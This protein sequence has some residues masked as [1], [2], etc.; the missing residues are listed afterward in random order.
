MSASTVAHDKCGNCDE[1]LD[2]SSQDVVR[3]NGSCGHVLHAACWLQRMIVSPTDGCSLCPQVPSIL[4]KSPLE[5]KTQTFFGSKTEVVS[6]AATAQGKGIWGRAWDTF[7]A[8]LSS[9][10]DDTH[11]ARLRANLPVV[12]LQHQGFTAEKLLGEL[13]YGVVPFLV[14]ETRYSSFQLSEL[15]FRWEH[16]VRGGLTETNFSSVLK[17]FGRSFLTDAVLNI[18]NLMDLCGKDPHRLAS[19]GIPAPYWS[20]LVAPNIM[21]IVALEKAGVRVQHFALFNFTMEE[22]RDE[23]GLTPTLLARMK[24]TRRDIEEFWCH[25]NPD[26]IDHFHLIFPVS[27]QKQVRPKF[28][29]SKG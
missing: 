23:M 19:L 14:K 9:A 8:L 22:W 25:S 11:A 26:E 18:A 4:Y 17:H 27:A 28:G 1:K 7:D 12:E 5:I 21:P 15:G 10:V 24:P 3:L 6:S 29:V 2:E 13:K 16:Y 20:S